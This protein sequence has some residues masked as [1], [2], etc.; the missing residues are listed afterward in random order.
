[1]KKLF[2]MLTLFVAAG[3][4]QFQFGTGTI[5]A[6]N[7]NCVQNACVSLALTSAASTANVQITGTFSGITFNFEA[8]SSIITSPV[9]ITCASSDGSSAATT[10]AAVGVYVCKIPAYTTLNVRA[11]AYGSGTATVNIKQSTAMAGG[12]G[13]GGIVPGSLAISGCL[14]VGSGAIPCGPQL[15][16]FAFYFGPGATETSTVNVRT[17][18]TGPDSAGPNS[19]VVTPFYSQLT[20]SPSADLVT[21]FLFPTG[22]VTGIYVPSTNTHTV[23]LPTGLLSVSEFNSPPATAY[24]A[25]GA[26][27]MKSTMFFG[28]FAGTGNVVAESPIVVDAGAEIGPNATVTGDASVVLA[29]IDLESPG[30]T[31][32]VWAFDGWMYVTVPGSNT[33]GF[34]G[35]YRG[36]EL[37]N[38]AGTQYGWLQKVMHN[39]ANACGMCIEN[40]T[41]EFNAT[42][43]SDGTNPANAS[44]TIIGS[45]TYTFKTTLAACSANDIKLGTAD[46]DTLN[47]LA[48]AT[49][50]L[51]TAGV[52]Y[53][54]GT[55]ANA[56]VDNYLLAAGGNIFTVL[57]ASASTL[58][59]TTHLVASSA[60]LVAGEAYAIQTDVLGE[61]G[62]GNLGGT[63]TRIVDANS[64]GDLTATRLAPFPIVRTAQVA[65]I[66][67]TNIIAS[68]PANSLYQAIAALDCTTVSAAA[69]VTVTIAWTDTGS[70]AQSITSG[71]A[72]CTALGSGSFVSLDQPFSA[73][74]GTAITYAT[75]ITNTPTYDL[76][77]S[78]SQLTTN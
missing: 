73:K 51:G 72:T 47:N 43:T 21:G 33:T 60:N 58:T 38:A 46:T 44:T 57:G 22:A 4:A 13:S 41:A 6:S 65:A 66:T 26:T 67:A 64:V 29:S 50:A 23:T 42:L 49:L 34:W 48:L 28:G 7:S 70:H 12:L 11:S 20:V 40:V 71:N 15:S 55:T 54:A 35:N 14:G 52:N 77:V 74:S 31:G 59:G 76:R 8:V 68:V 27:G 69:V 10:A 56:A 75:T 24:T 30:N 16:D 17:S 2:L 45:K 18:Y 61:I 62:L 63:G 37:K 19:S 53:C 78:L 36:R 3:L 1:M 32:N 25:S 39:A 5:T 9:P